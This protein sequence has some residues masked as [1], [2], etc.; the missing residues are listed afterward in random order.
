MKRLE[1]HLEPTPQSE[2][3]CLTKCKWGYTS[4]QTLPFTNAPLHT[5]LKGPTL[6]SPEILNDFSLIESMEIGVIKY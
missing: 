5:A 4:P 1:K 3:A 6:F 2:P